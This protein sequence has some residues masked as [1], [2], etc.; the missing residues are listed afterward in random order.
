M[1]T[2]KTWLSVYCGLQLFQE[3]QIEEMIYVRSA[4]ESSDQKLGFLR[5]TR[6]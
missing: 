3:Q 5:S 4:V 2:A 1:G 6:R